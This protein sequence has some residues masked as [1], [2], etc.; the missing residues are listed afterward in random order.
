MLSLE[1]TQPNCILMSFG[2]VYFGH[3]KL[4]S[5]VWVLGQRRRPPIMWLCGWFHWKP[6]EW[7][8]RFP[9][10][11]FQKKLTYLKF[12][13]SLRST[14]SARETLP[15][16]ECS[17]WS[18]KRAVKSEKK[19][20]T[21]RFR[22]RKKE[23]KIFY[24]NG[25]RAAHLVSVFVWVQLASSTRERDLLPNYFRFLVLSLFSLF[26]LLLSIIDR[27]NERVSQRFNQTASAARTYRMDFYRASKLI[28]FERKKTNLSPL[29]SI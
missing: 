18:R 17:L 15:G 22:T 7:P 4:H 28:L 24:E 2:P 6:N 12:V 26:R 11:A 13:Y 9:S 27:P 25:R 29:W 3:K 10:N 1:L 23:R 5:K 8:L 19:E 16:R 14:V 20:V 21:F